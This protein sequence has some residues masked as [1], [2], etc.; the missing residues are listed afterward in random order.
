MYRLC[1]EAYENHLDIII[2][3]KNLKFLKMFLGS[4]KKLLFSLF[5]GLCYF[6]CSQ[7]ADS[8]NKI[9]L[10]TFSCSVCK[11]GKDRN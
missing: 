3:I 9:A 8:Q 11:V 5:R 2:E 4:G 10:N 6:V 7:L 1:F